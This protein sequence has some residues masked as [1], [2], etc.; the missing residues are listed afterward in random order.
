MHNGEISSYDANRRYIEMF[1]YACTLKTDTEAITYI[2]D[3]LVRKRGLT[4]EET[5]GVIA[6]PFWSTIEAKEPEEREKL[7]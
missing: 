3:Y 2:I 4:L 7:N 6:A 5:A 1:G